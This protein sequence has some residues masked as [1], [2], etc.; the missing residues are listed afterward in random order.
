MDGELDLVCAPGNARPGRTSAMRTL[1]ARAVVASLVRCGALGSEDAEES[2][3][4]IGD[5]T[6]S[7]RLDG[8]E[9]ARQLERR[10][11]WDCGMQIAEELDRFESV[12]D[13]IHGEAVA[14]WALENPSRAEFAEGDRV[15]WRGMPATVSGVDPHRPLSYRISCEGRDPGSVLIVP[16]ED[17]SGA[18]AA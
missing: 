11:H 13:R 1:A 17:I 10:R 15:I 2:V 14:K 4:D 16:F 8:Y 9:I 12:L 6:R 7:G 3:E 18:R 5:A